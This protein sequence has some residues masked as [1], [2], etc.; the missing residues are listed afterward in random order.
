[1]FFSNM[2]EWK[3]MSFLKQNSRHVFNDRSAKDSIVGF[4]EQNDD[5]FDKVYKCIEL[6]KDE[7][8]LLVKQS[9]GEIQKMR[10]GIKLGMKFLS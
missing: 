8:E 6:N 5:N 1:M 9:G 3:N 4:F 2:N 10:I 7:N